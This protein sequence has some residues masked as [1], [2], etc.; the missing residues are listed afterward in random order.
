MRTKGET[1]SVILDSFDSKVTRHP[2]DLRAQADINQ[3]QAL[4]W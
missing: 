3:R 1:G 2:V 4:M